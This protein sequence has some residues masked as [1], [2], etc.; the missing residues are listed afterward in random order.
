MIL[1][2]FVA[3]D[4]WRGTDMVAFGYMRG[5]GRR[6]TTDWLAPNCWAWRPETL[7]LLPYWLGAWAMQGLGAVGATRAGRAL[8]VHGHAGAHAVGHLAWRV[9]AGH[10]ALA[11]QPVAFAFGG[12]A[13]P[14]DYARAMADGGLLALLAC[15]GSGTACA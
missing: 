15:L 5:A 9:L 4:P 14:A 11:A 7:G 1:P 3:R 13:Q 10:A 2:G 6:A 8:A 12:E